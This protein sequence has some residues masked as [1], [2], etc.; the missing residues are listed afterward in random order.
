MSSEHLRVHDL[1]KVFPGRRPTVA[2]DGVNLT[3]ESGAFATVLGPS[4][5]GKT[6]L[7]RCI[8]GFE[9]PDA[10]TITL[11]ERELFGSSTSLQPY[12]R[13]VG[14]VP[15]EGALFPHLSVAQ[16]IAFGIADQP[17][18]MRARRVSELL[19]LVG[20]HGL[21][22]RR[23]HQLSGGQQQR[24][25]LARALAPE[26]QLILL[27]EPFSALDAQLRV[28][29]REE[30][31]SLLRQLGTTT[32][33]VT[34][35]Q[36]EAL[37]LADHLV[38]MRSGCVVSAG[39]PRQ[40]YETPVDAELG[41]FLGEAMV[42]PGVLDRDADALVVRCALGLLDVGSV[43]SANGVRLPAEC[44]VLVRPEQ[45]TLR[46][47]DGTGTPTDGN[48]AASSGVWEYAPTGVVIAH[49]F[50]GHDALVQVRLDAGPVIG[51]RVHGAE[52][53]NV[54]DV[55]A[56]RVETPVSTYEA[57]RGTPVTTI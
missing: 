51:V 5:S 14:V 32:L 10:G 11:G 39:E 25:A 20:L 44:E 50:F 18:D 48:S 54:G 1:R 49:S 2:L 53:F 33:L 35:D 46:P 56:A 45:L 38:V 37:A 3:V 57:S 15:Q 28:G 27:D 47:V 31:R 26:P 34:H 22:D 19:D 8:A 23:P 16:N 21:R 4:G 40:V 29:L 52:R 41:R 42:L 36:G 12:A 9:A 13:G 17:H 7:L 55:V 6:T 43:N 30:V 24:V